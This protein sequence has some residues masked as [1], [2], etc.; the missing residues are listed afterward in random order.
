MFAGKDFLTALIAVSSFAWRDSAF[1]S[2]ACELAMFMVFG[3]RW[4]T[5]RVERRSL[6][7]SAMPAEH[8][9]FF[10]ISAAVH[11]TNLGLNG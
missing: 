11:L 4:T 6:I 9:T 2:T 8:R 1:E 7:E 3:G 5:T 10:Q